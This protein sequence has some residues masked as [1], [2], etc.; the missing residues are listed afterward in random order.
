MCFTYV[1]T[2][3]SIFT[4]NENIIFTTKKE[5]Y[6]MWHLDFCIRYSIIKI[7]KNKYNSGLWKI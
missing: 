1:N 4:A 5:I 7:V 2:A 6:K 3:I